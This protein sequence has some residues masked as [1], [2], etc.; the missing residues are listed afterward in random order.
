MTINDLADALGLTKGTVSRALNGYTDISE[1]TR[2]RVAAMAE[3]MGYR[4]SAQ[5]RAIRTGR[6]HS[7][8][9]VLNVDAGNAHKPFLTDFID[10]ISRAVSAE[11]WT[12]TV[13]TAISETDEMATYRRLLDEKK[14]D[15]F[16]LPRT[17]IVDPR[18]DL[19]L[20]AN[21]PFVLYGRTGEMEGCASV[22]VAGELAMRHA[23]ELLSGLGHRKIGYVGGGAVYNYAPLRLEGFLD[24]MRRCGLAVDPDLITS[25][26]MTPDEGHALAMR[27]LTRDAPPTAIVAALDQAAL[28]VCAAAQACGLDVGRDLSVIGYDGIPEGAY[29]RPP[30]TTFAVDRRAAGSALAG[31]LLA[32]IRGTRAEDLRQLLEAQLVLRGSHGP[33]AGDSAALA[34]RI[35]AATP[36]TA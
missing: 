6:A 24:G 5:A 8:G 30:L 35:E 12:L 15:G 36:A 22:D 7:I 10:G 31:M 16:I 19:L 18:V 33:P 11:N 13:A 4:A 9:L 32:R 1:T 21:M 2:H 26:A 27:M 34:A 17:R 28:G 14:V 23:V 25:G 29:A 20:R 3:T